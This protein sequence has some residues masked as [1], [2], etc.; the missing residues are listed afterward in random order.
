MKR[1]EE[2]N[3]LLS[4]ELQKQKLI[5]EQLEQKL[6]QQ[7]KFHQISQTVFENTINLIQSLPHNSPYR[8]PLL[9]WFTKNLSIDDSMT[10]Y[11]ISKRIYN[12]LI[13]QKDSEIVARKYGIGVT[14][15]RI[16]QEQ[17]LEITRILDDILPVQS[18]RNYRYQETTDRQLY[19]TYYSEVINGNPVSKSFFYLFSGSKRKNE[20]FKNKKILSIV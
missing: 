15:E 12:R 19:N 9:F 11:G 6:S 10:V 8:R 14:R 20:T 7:V 16:S 2:E 5:I 18:G 1:L 13:E 3:S 4:A 17:R